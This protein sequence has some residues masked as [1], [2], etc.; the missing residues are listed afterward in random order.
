MKALIF[1]LLLS[2]PSGFAID[3]NLATNQQLLDEVGR[4]LGS[5]STG[6]NAIASY[7][8]DSSYLRT[9]VIGV[10]NKAE[11]STYIG[12]LG[13]C[14]EQSGVLNQ[15]KTKI[16]GLT[17]VAI[18]DSSYLRRYKMLPAGTISEVDST[19]MGDYNRCVTQ[20]K[21]LNQN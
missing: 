14:Q 18:C 12:D 7:I 17:L 11:L 13:R 5:P 20:A 1:G 19:Y 10:S 15:Y 8:C 3:L 4:R 16:Y 6:E 9:S 21:L 2:I